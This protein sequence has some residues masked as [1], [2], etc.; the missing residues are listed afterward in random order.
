MSKNKL[1]LV[2]GSSIAF[3]AFFAIQNIE[4][5]KNSSGLYTNAIYGFHTMLSNIIKKVSPTHI[6]VAFDAGKTTFRTEMFAEYKGGRQK[7]VPEFREQLPFIREMLKYQ[8]IHTYELVNYEADDI[9]GTLAKQ[10]EAADFE[11]EI[12]SGD[13]DLTQLTTE[14]TTVQITRKGVDN[15]ET[16]TP[17]Y[18]FEKLGINPTQLIDL[19]A[20]MGDSSDN[21]PGVT[22]IGEKTG[23][24]L[25]TAYQSLEN[26][27]EHIDE[28]KKSKMKENLINEKD[29]AFLSKKLATI[30]TASPLEISVTD[31]AVSP[32]DSEGL[33][34]FYEQMNF[35]KFIENE[36]GEAE[37]TLEAIDYQLVRDYQAGM[38]SKGDF[39]YLETL[40]DN[41]HTADVISV[42]WGNAKKQY[43]AKADVLFNNPEFEKDVQENFSKTYDFKKTKILLSRYQIEIDTIEFD[44]LLAKYILNAETSHTFKIIAGQYT[45]IEIE[46]DEAVYGKGAKQAIPADE[47][48]FAHLARKLAILVSSEQSM[49]EVLESNNQLH[50]LQEIEQPLAGVLAKMEMR[51]IKVDTNR[52]EEMKVEYMAILA[53]I[54]KTI[55]ELAGEQFNINSPKQ[56]SVIL[57]EKLQL[58]VIKKTKTGY[59]TAVDVLE[60]LAPQAPIVEHILKYRQIAKILS[61]Y[62]EGLLKVVAADGKVHTRYIQTLTATGRLSSVDP[63]LQNIP[64][65]IE[66]GRR[67]RE[68]FLPSFEDGYIYS[69]DYSQIELRVLA[70]ISGDEH[71]RLAFEEKQ[72]IHTATAMRVFGIEE[73][74]QVDGNIRRKAKAVN[75]GV[76]YGISDY[77]L[78]ENLGISR[79]EAGD[80]IKTYF[81]KYPGI[82]KYMEEIVREARDKGYVETLFHRR[83]EIL[84]INSRNFNRRSFAE[85]TAINSP[86]QGSAADILKVAMIRLESEISKAGLKA[87]MLLQVHDEVVFE[88]PASEIDQLDQI[89]KDIMEHTTEL[90]VPLIADSNYGRNWYDAK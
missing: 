73:A 39:L 9:I 8:G 64:I 50:L 87:R 51:G 42:A 10:A 18:M 36:L 43:V 67:V 32:V 49:L 52:L 33:R 78:A 54:E 44:T 15:L 29:I 76:V 4:N 24:K 57:F 83:R 82:K 88:V 1:L 21:I 77:G 6:L 62:L 61:T 40:A 46:T 90:A 55:F 30:D 66:E 12:F 74:S 89:V 56:L 35:N 70:D 5:F 80:Y 34:H 25:I 68:A 23:L 58:P 17:D 53:D 60:K 13:R 48:L 69:S 3:R 16:Y 27:Y 28:L 47:I 85:R 26:L 22:K 65:R 31:L 19:K 41:Y 81:E 86:I 71:L 84:E 20:L 7:I 59:S 63:N 14:K 38:F 79:K 2:D 72:D 11:V 75:F 37:V 45:S